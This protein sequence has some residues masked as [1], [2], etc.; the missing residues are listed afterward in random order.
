[1]CVCVCVC[2][3]YDVSN[4]ETFQNLEV[5]LNELD[6]YATKKGL[7]KMLVGNK[8]DKETRGVS[9]SDGLQFARRNSML[10]IEARSVSHTHFS[11]R[12]C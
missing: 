12:L 4:R 10:F 8:I 9:R 7:V 1:M 2:V 3:V 6:T 5:W 11:W